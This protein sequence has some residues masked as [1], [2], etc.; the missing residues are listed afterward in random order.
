MEDRAYWEAKMSAASDTL[1]AALHVAKKNRFKIAVA[2]K[3]F[4][5]VCDEYDVFRAAEIAADKIESS[6]EEEAP[7]F[8]SSQLELF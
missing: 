3:A 2:R 6:R 5:T 4:E 1:K 7:Q 8:E